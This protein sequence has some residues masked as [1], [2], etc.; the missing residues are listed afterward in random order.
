MNAK[1]KKQSRKAKSGIA[2]AIALAGS[3]EALAVRLGVTKQAVQKWAQ[4]GYVPPN[5][6]LM[7]ASEFH[8]PK[9]DLLDMRLSELMNPEVGE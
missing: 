5:R 2:Q 7:I 8:I 1:Y 9:R 3:Q 4:R 6:V